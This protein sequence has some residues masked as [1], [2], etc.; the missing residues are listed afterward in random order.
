[1]TG[2]I[3]LAQQA[4]E[5]RPNIAEDNKA[6]TWKDTAEFLANTIKTYSRKMEI[7]QESLQIE[8]VSSPKQCVV[9]F[10]NHS[11]AGE[12]LSCN[13]LQDTSEGILGVTFVPP[14]PE[15]ISRAGKEGYVIEKI[16]PGSLAADAAIPL[17]SV[18]LNVGL[19]QGYMIHSFR[20]DSET[21]LQRMIHA[22]DW[23]NAKHVWL[24]Y[25]DKSNHYK[26][27]YRQFKF[28]GICHSPRSVTR[29]CAI[30]MVRVDPLSIELV[31]SRLTLS[32]TDLRAFG[33][34][35]TDEPGIS[36][37]PMNQTLSVEFADRDIGKRV[38][39]A[40]LHASVMCGGTKAVS[41]F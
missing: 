35:S 6:A 25:R 30:D 36:G 10:T 19:S 20:L 13:L 29:E 39:R 26:K 8:D 3:A 9:S 16:L 40:L 2:T 32:G 21:N 37:K 1:M 11:L 18:L 31:D 17:G 22:G 4:V 12:I 7:N 34:C 15:V 23:I 41:P 5:W 27:E 14:S 28:D 33:T 24:Y 38:A